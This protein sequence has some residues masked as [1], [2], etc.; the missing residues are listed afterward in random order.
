M[1]PGIEKAKRLAGRRSKRTLQ[2]NM[3]VCDW[4]VPLPNVLQ[5]YTSFIDTDQES[6]LA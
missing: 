2:E 5:K 3:A 1:K 6:I 4:N